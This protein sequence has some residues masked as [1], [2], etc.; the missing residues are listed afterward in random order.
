[1]R[2]GTG[3]D[4][5]LSRNQVETWSPP[6]KIAKDRLKERERRTPVR[7]SNAVHVISVHLAWLV[8]S[9]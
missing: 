7:L 2:S 1:M 3:C 5:S 9:F 4:W 8:R 6:S